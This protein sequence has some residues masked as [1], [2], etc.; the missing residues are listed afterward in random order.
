MLLALYDGAPI[1]PVDAVCRDFFS[2]L[3]PVKFLAKVDR[4]EISIPV[5]RIEASQKSAKGVHISD[6]ASW[7]DER[8]A[9][10]VRECKALAGS[11]ARAHL[12]T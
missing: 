7:I 8:R 1:V 5:V 3:S 2:H 6:L 9:I 12:T 11:G 10:A 4:G